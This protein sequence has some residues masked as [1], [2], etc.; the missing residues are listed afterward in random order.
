MTFREEFGTCPE[1]SFRVLQILE[2]HSKVVA[3]SVKELVFRKLVK[4]VGW[5]KFLENFQEGFQECKE[6]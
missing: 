2:R 5:R 1:T 6:L 4:I 3:K